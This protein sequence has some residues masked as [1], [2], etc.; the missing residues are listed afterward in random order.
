MVLGNDRPFLPAAFSGAA[1]HEELCAPLGTSSAS[2]CVR[3]PG[4]AW[5]SSPCPG[6][7]GSGPS[8]AGP[9][10]VSPLSPLRPPRSR[11]P[12]SPPADPAGRG[13]RRGSLPSGT[14]Q[15][16]G[17]KSPVPPPLA[18]QAGGHRWPLGATLVRGWGSA[19]LSTARVPLSETESCESSLFS[20]KEA[21]SA[22]FP[23]PPA[24]RRSPS[25]RPEVRGRRWHHWDSRCLSWKATNG[26]PGALG[27]GLE[28][29]LPARARQECVQRAGRLEPRFLRVPGIFGMFQ[30][31]T[32]AP[33]G[34]RQ[35]PGSTA[36]AAWAQLR[37]PGGFGGSWH[38][39]RGGAVRVKEPQ[40]AWR[41][42]G[43]RRGPDFVVSSPH[44]SLGRPGLTG[45][46]GDK[47]PLVTAPPV[48]SRS[49]VPVSAPRGCRAAALAP[50]PTKCS[51][52]PKFP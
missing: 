12:T 19:G 14:A 24:R 34:G 35:G 16:W 25:T 41:A 38:R 10:G 11:S 47:V 30:R 17:V 40:R 4:I 26:L 23:A 20:E 22:C 9:C 46:T 48:P 15:F 42:S 36:S 7:D 5:K 52:S 44:S 45:A 32:P 27:K 49:G 8:P 6:Q 18:L 33:G 39:L 43:V 51:N 3:S 21:T 37:H 31:L 29:L 28:Q 50:Y 13:D 2:P 1:F